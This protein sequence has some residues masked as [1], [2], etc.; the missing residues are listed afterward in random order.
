M[1]IYTKLKALR[2]QRLRAFICLASNNFG[3]KK[4]AYWSKLI[5]FGVPITLSTSS[6]DEPTLKHHPLLKQA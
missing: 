4:K 6:S 1:K 5:L 2:R 3:A